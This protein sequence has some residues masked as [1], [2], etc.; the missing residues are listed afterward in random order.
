MTT[1]TKVETYNLTARN[2]CHIRMATK[3]VFADGR[4]V[5]FLDRMGKA[6]AIRQAEMHLARE[7]K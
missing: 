4:E 1:G 5:K 3:V 6:E 2:G 7:A